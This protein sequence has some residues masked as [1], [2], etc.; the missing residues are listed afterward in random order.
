MFFSLYRALETKFELNGRMRGGAYAPASDWLFGCWGRGERLWA[1]E[2]PA[3]L[4]T[5]CATAAP[6]G[7]AASASTF[8]AMPPDV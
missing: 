3:K 7:F 6:P 8:L 4:R 2:L 5:G 1:G